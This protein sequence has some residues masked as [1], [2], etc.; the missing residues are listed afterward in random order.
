M[1]DALTAYHFRPKGKYLVY[2]DVDR[3]DFMDTVLTMQQGG[4]VSLPSTT[5]SIGEERISP[6]AFLLDQTPTSLTDQQLRRRRA[7]L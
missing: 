2:F 1:F 5:I 7:L 6:K 3:G 4:V